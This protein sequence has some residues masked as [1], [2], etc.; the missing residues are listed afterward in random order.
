AAR[1]G[2]RFASRMALV[3]PGAGVLAYLY[4]LAANSRA[5]LYY[6]PWGLLGVCRL[7]GWAVLVFGIVKLDVLGIELP[8]FVVRR[9]AVA[10]GALALL[11]IVAQLAQNFFSAEFGLLSGG[12]IA[13]TFL[14]AASP[15]QRAFERMGERTTKAISEPAAPAFH[16]PTPRQEEAFREA[17]RFALRDHRLT[18][19]EEVR[20]FRVAEALGISAGRAMELRHEVERAQGVR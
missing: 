4:L 2:D 15:L 8:H 11:F 12:V 20:L 1:S 7:V 16:Q 17:V 19:E 3:W 18:G 14:F 13:G 10:G 5:D 6:D 9:G